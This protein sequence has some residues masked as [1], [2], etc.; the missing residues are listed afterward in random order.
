M[1]LP[2]TCQLVGVAVMLSTILI[3]PLTTAFA[4]LT[5]TSG[6]STAPVSNTRLFQSSST[7]SPEIANRLRADL[8]DVLERGSPLSPQDTVL[9]RHR[10]P[11]I[12]QDDR[13]HVVKSLRMLNRMASIGVEATEEDYQLVLRALLSRGRLRW[14]VETTTSDDDSFQPRSSTSVTCAAD[15][16]ELLLP[17]VTHPEDTTK[18][19]TAT[20]NLVLEGYAVCASPRGARDYAVRAQELYDSMEAPDAMS[21]VH[22]LHAWAWQQA[23]KQP[24]DPC[25][26]KATALLD[27]LM[28]ERRQVLNSVQDDD[29]DETATTT[30]DLF[31]VE[32]GL[33]LECHDWVLEAWSKSL[34]H[35]SNALAVFQQRLELMESMNNAIDDTKVHHPD[36]VTQPQQVPTKHRIPMSTYT[37][38]IVALTRK[39][40]MDRNRDDHQDY[41]KQQQEQY[42]AV[43]LAQDYLYEMS[44]RYL[45]GKY[46][47]GNDQPE[48]IA[49][50]SVISAWS[51]LEEPQKAEDVLWYAENQLAP[52]APGIRV[53]TLTCNV[54]LHAYTA[55]GKRQGVTHASR[56]VMERVE[57][58]VEFMEVES[59]KRP[60]LRP[61]CY[62]YTVLLKV[63]VCVCVYERRDET[64]VNCSKD[65][66]RRDVVAIVLGW[67]MSCVQKDRLSC[68]VV[69]CPIHSY[70]PTNTH[71]H[72]YT[73]SFIRPSSLVVSHSLWTWSKRLSK[74]WT[75]PLIPPRRTPTTRSKP[76]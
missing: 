56:K 20:Y 23:S 55:R 71:T 7:S 60:E 45:D 30:K 3:L 40:R 36:E 19:S 65:Q 4:P 5:Q 67:V 54:V 22:L 62:S 18:W 31:A 37:N 72:K 66:E 17:K 61:N 1:T 53:D 70:P 33:L 68:V 39:R 46:F 51:R 21:K 41:H 10:K 69:A 57:G 2:W 14:I 59:N 34:G 73:H 24:A 9:E 38:L 13:D 28:Q 15:Q 52:Y 63:C 74:R 32:D 64:K 47:D 76:L 44:E 35:Y 8:R 16:M 25:A 43:S 12:L 50:N 49:Y 58:L 26:T 27:E 11:A 29:D 48:F 6:L 42:N 75:S